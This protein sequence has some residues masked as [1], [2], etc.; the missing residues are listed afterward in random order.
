M[1]RRFLISLFSVLV[2]VPAVSAAADISGK[3]NLVWNTEGGVRETQWTIAQDGDAITVDAG[4]QV[5]KGTVDGDRMVV[6]GDFYSPEAGYSSTIKV[7]GTL[8]DG[9]MKG[10]GTW[11]QYGM[12]FV[13][14]RAE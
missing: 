9:T 10:K 12:T 8:Q 11:D 1:H 13:A 5:L 6:E 3:W 7:E 2:G 4:G 14:T